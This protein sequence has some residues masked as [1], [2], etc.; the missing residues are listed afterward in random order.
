MRNTVCASLSVSWWIITCVIQ[1]LLELYFGLSKYGFD[2]CYLK[3]A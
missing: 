2:Y 1:I 3:R